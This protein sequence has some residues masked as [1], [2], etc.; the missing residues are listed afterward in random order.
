MAALEWL[1]MLVIV[2]SGILAMRSERKEQVEERG[3]ES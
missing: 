2:A 1:G 3:F